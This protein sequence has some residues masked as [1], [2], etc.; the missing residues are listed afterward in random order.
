MAIKDKPDHAESLFLLA[1]CLAR[2]GQVQEAIPYARRAGR[3][4]PNSPKIHGQLG[5]LCCS[6]GHYT[7]AIHHLEIAHRAAPRDAAIAS[8]LAW[9][10]A[11]AP[12]ASLRDGARANLS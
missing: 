1:S 9:V 7:E 2:S 4:V 6:T 10:L 8:N 3:I 5:A 11:A 12:N